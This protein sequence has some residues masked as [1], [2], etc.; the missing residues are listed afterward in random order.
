MWW[1]MGKFFFKPEEREGQHVKIIGNTAH[2]MLNVLRIRIGQELTLCDGQCVDYFARLESIALKPAAVVFELLSS[3]PCKTEPVVPITLYQGMPKGDKMEWIIEKCIEAGISKIV[4]VLTART[5]VKI[6]SATQKGERYNRIA[7]SAAAQSMRGI[8]PI[9]SPPVS[10]LEALASIHKG[11]LLVAYEKEQC[12][13]IKSA[14][15]N[16]APTPVSLWVGP[17]GGFEES[18]IQTLAEK[19]V[20]PISLG[21]R[22]LRT[23]TAGLVALSQ[24]NCIWE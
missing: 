3:S 1:R 14:L 2:H 10:F 23:E 7:E 9:I 16:I 8:V 12:R 18:E 20:L 15:E 19:G 21:H 24:I 6:S 4:P 11:L 22:V 5:V 13:T 17:E